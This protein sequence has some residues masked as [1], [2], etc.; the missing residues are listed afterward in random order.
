MKHKTD[1]P[2]V[3]KKRILKKTFNEAK[4]SSY[5]TSS[6]S[7]EEVIDRIRKTR[8]KLWKGKYKEWFW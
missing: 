6:L 3:K 1:E 2:L 5:D 4:D 8:I 7:K